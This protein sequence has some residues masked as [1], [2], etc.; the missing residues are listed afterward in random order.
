MNLIFMHV[1]MYQETTRGQVT[2]IGG[3]VLIKFGHSQVNLEK[4]QIFVPE[5]PIFS[6]MI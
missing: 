3:Y 6:K 2:P 1:R 5:I 4:Y